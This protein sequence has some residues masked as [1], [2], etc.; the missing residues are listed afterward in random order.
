MIA[1]LAACNV[2]G[3]LTTTV[4]EERFL[5]GYPLLNHLPPHVRQA[6]I[7]ALEAVGEVQVVEAEEV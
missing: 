2:G 4:R 3:R 7:A 1:I 5:S 6:E